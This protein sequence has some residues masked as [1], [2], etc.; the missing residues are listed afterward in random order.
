MNENLKKIVKEIIARNRQQ[1][2]IIVSDATYGTH[3][4][5]KHKGKMTRFLLND[6]GSN[7]TRKN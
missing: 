5:N 4:V 7:L 1:S 2:K 6:S 3:I